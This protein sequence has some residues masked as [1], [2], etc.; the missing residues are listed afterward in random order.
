MGCAICHRDTICWPWCFNCAMK[1]KEGI[2]NEDG[3]PCKKKE[4]RRPS[5]DN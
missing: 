5:H 4:K 1:L 3:T 2:I